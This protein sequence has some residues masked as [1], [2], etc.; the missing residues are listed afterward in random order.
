MCKREGIDAMSTI[1]FSVQEGGELPLKLPLHLVSGQMQL[2][3]GPPTFRATQDGGRIEDLVVR[4]AQAQLSDADYGFAV[5]QRFFITRTRPGLRFEGNL[6]IDLDGFDEEDNLF[7]ALKD[8]AV[9][10]VPVIVTLGVAASDGSTGVID[11][12][13]QLSQ[14]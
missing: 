9:R 1:I 14:Q 4:S 2:V 13:L 8:A 6:G 3:D 7:L 11:V 12:Q 10:D 5:V